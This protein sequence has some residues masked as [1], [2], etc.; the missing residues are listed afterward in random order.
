MTCLYAPH[1]HTHP[2]AK[3]SAGSRSRGLAPFISLYSAP[4][5]ELTDEWMVDQGQLSFL[6]VKGPSCKH[7]SQTGEGEDRRRRQ[8]IV[9]DIPIITKHT[10]G[11]W[12]LGGLH[13]FL[14]IM[15]LGPERA[16]LQASPAHPLCNTHL[17]AER[18]PNTLTEVVLYR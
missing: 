16:L 14:P 2:D 7:P 12:T 17:Y 1:T 4:G 6:C 10:R 8:S 15:F 9:G 3:L 11:S 13:S 5:S 18:H